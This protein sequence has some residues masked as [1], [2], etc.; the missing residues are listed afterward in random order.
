MKDSLRVHFCE[1]H[2]SPIGKVW[3]SFAD[4][5]ELLAIGLPGSKGWRAK[6]V[7]PQVA[8]SRT[9][10]G[11]WLSSF[12]CGESVDFPGPWRMPGHSPFLSKVYRFV[13]RIPVGHTKS[14][15]EVAKACGSSR[16]CRA[17]GTAMAQNPMPLLVPCHRVL[18]KGGMGGFAGGLEQ[19]ADLL[20]CEAR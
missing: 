11:R 6:G 7:R 8:P 16:A 15:S 12:M 20:A 1:S 5:G 14:Y 19:K 2:D 9:A 17:V 13:S 18:A 3:F 4:D 10:V